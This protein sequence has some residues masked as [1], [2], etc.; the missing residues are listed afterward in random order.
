[1]Y[2][3]LKKVLENRSLQVQEA[4]SATS[5][6]SAQT[7]TAMTRRILQLAAI[8]RSTF[9]M[10]P[11]VMRDVLSVGEAMPTWLQCASLIHSF[12]PPEAVLSPALRVL[13]S[14]DRILAIQ[15]LSA[16][17]SVLETDSI[18]LDRAVHRLWAG[19]NSTGRR[20]RTVGDSWMSTTT[21]GGAQL[22]ARVVHF[23][24][25][26]GNLFVDGR[27]I[28]SLPKAITQHETFKILFPH[29][30]T[31]PSQCWLW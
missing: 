31:L 14:R 19:Y 9:D 6:A 4:K 25:I 22:Q 8:V 27:T 21:R 17:R 20:W 7:E 3:W 1:M 16:V 18:G 26:S 11:R 12:S 10:E 29:S 13:L 28:G 24:L 2:G 30:V 15:N 23:N 5:A